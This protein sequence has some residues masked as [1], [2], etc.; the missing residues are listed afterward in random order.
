MVDDC[1]VDV[2][3][4]RAGEEG[5]VDREVRVLVEGD[6]RVEV[7]AEGRSGSVEDLEHGRDLRHVLRL[8]ARDGGLR[9][10]CKNVRVEWNDGPHFAVA[11]V[12]QSGL[13]VAESGV[14]RVE[15]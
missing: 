11:C 14:R 15:V 8:E 13:N 3:A 4:R 6:V 2:R 7:Y 1:A 12:V 5:V 9:G 10:V